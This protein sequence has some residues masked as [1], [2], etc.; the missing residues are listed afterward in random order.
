M[1]SRQ[2][3]ILYIISAAFFF[4]LMN[5]FVRLAGDI[6]SIQ[7]SFFRNLIAEIL[8]FYASGKLPFNPAETLE[9]ARIR[10][11]AIE[12]KNKIAGKDTDG[13][14]TPLWDKNTKI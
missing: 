2:K 12:C 11:V 3:A 4:S 9:I 13:E 1:K 8:K 7:K 14:W 5:T 10:E 6:P